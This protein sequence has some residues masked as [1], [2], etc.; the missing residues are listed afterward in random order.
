MVC[1]IWC[2]RKVVCCSIH[3]HAHA[4]TLQ[5]HPFFKCTHSS[6]APTPTFTYSYYGVLALSVQPTSVQMSTVNHLVQHTLHTQPLPSSAAA[7]AVCCAAP[8]Q[9]QLLMEYTPWWQC[10]VRGRGGRGAG[11]SNTSMCVLSWEWW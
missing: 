10:L 6:N 11:P 1:N 8:Q 9:L 3:T 7:A 5:M 2:V 4:P